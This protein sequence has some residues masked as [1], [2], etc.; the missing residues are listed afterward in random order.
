M[1]GHGITC[2]G[3]H[4][5]STTLNLILYSEFRLQKSRS[6]ANHRTGIGPGTQQTAGAETF[7]AGEETKQSATHIHIHHQLLAPAPNVRGGGAAA[8]TLFVAASAAQATPTISPA[9]CGAT[10]VHEP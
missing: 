7:T 6:M 2:D 1:G 10:G 9:P 3:D 4:E 5:S 8:A